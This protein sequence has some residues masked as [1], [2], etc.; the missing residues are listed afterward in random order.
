MI[1]SSINLYHPLW[2]TS[3]FCTSKLLSVALDVPPI[4]N[5]GLPPDLHLTNL[6]DPL[7]SVTGRSTSWNLWGLQLFDLGWPSSGTPGVG[8]DGREGAR[9]LR[10]PHATP[11][12]HS[13]V[14][15][16]VLLQE[17]IAVA[18]RFHNSWRR[19]NLRAW[20][21][22]LSLC[23]SETNTAPLGQHPLHTPADT[24]RPLPP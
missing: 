12:C 16:P 22:S 9:C 19:C 2:G 18:R 24:L 8:G 21:V 11:L 5:S 15:S 20:S 3:L 13:P 6:T 23:T 7:T 17:G 10:S 4:L 1:R 14:A